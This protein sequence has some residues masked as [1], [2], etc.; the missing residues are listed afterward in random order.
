MIT[1]PIFPLQT[2]LF[3]GGTL[4]L[5]VFEQRYMD[6]VKECLKDEQP[7]GICLIASGNEVSTQLGDAAHPHSIGV[8]ARITSWDMAQLGVLNIAVAGEERFI[9][10][11]HETNSQGLVVAQ[12]RSMPNEDVLPVPAEHQSMVRLLQMMVADVV[13]T[14]GGARLPLP[15]SFESAAWV[16]YRFCELLP[17]QALARQKLL[18]LEDPLNRLDIV[19]KFL[20][21]RG[22][23]E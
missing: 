23:V 18:E 17:M 8:K 3:P 7:F 22:L 2:V 1:L 20:V 10:E 5:R 4:T 21:Q 13:A 11:S 6:M 15:H 19:H 12:V 16:G 9:I 14:M